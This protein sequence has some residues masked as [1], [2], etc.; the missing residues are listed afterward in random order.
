MNG[1]LSAAIGSDL[2]ADVYKRTLYQPYTVHVNRNSSEVI[3]KITT[4]VGGAVA[5]LNA[6][7]QLFT[8]TIVSVSLVYGL[9]LI[10]LK[11]AVITAL[12]FGTL[13]LALSTITKKRLIINSRKIANA[14]SQNLK[15]LHEG[16]GAIRDVILDGTQNLYLKIY[17]NSD[18]PKRNLYAQNTFLSLF[19][20]YAFESVGMVA[21]AILGFLMTKQ[22]SSFQVII[23]LLGGLA[24]GAQRLLPA[25]QQVYSSWSSLKSYHSALCDVSEI[26]K[27]D[28]P[29]HPGASHLI[30]IKKNLVLKNIDFSYRSD[31]PKVISNLSLEIKAGSCIGLIGSTGSGKSTLTDIMMGLLE[32]TKGTILVDEIPISNSGSKQNLE[33]WRASVAHVPQNIYLTDNSIAENIAFGIPKKSIDFNRVMMAAQQAQI[34]SFIESTPF[35]YHTSV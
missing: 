13:Y 4:Q 31:T 9:M 20:R 6:L 3:T 11:V 27:Y 29:V 25:M 18:R 15:S 1:K 30:P 22:E 34:S 24:L 2:S 26:I 17:N 35:G 33:N 21:I 23:P 32:P 28:M 19:P 7:L 16:L 12:I 14:E 10:D 5:A 8:S